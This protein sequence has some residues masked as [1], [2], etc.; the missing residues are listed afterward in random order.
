MVQ[1]DR[2]CLGS[3]RTQVQ[4]LAQWHNGLRIWGCHSC[5]F[6]HN[7]CSDLIP[8]LGTPCASGRPRMGEKEKAKVNRMSL[9][10]L[11]TR[12]VGQR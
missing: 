11:S 4:S 3:A 8:G 6:S 1:R 12:G 7:Y 5:G 9:G 10:G 2:Q